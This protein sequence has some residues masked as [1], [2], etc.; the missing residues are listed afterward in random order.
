M[1]GAI[2]LDDRV[3]WPS[4]FPIKSIFPNSMYEVYFIHFIVDDVVI[5][6]RPF[7]FQVLMVLRSSALHLTTTKFS[8]LK[9]QWEK[10]T[11]KKEWGWVRLQ[12]FSSTC[13][14][15]SELRLGVTMLSATLNTRSVPT[16][17]CPKAQLVDLK[18]C[19]RQGFIAP[20]LPLEGLVLRSGWGRENL[21]ISIRRNPKIGLIG[22]VLW[23]SN[24]I[25][26][27]I[28]STT[29][30]SEFSKRR[31]PCCARRRSHCLW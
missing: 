25:F 23:S 3:H 22:W 2:I 14:G 30:P 29:C 31:W 5:I 8:T 7:T 6:T 27:G 18:T 26:Y 28:K 21:N 13:L 16:W 24:K 20:D 9:R 19:I 17:S 10:K 1:T 12:F 4:L 11:L 15:Y